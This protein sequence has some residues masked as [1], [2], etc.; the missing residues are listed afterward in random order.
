M[1]R[2]VLAANE[3]ALGPDDG[4]TLFVMFNLAKVRRSQAAAGD[5]AGP[6]A[7]GAAV[8]AEAL[9]RR[10][11]AGN[12]AAG[13]AATDVRILNVVHSLGDLL[14]TRAEETALEAGEVRPSS[15]ARG[16]KKKKKKE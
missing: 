12:E 16:G 10:T 11:L 7:A 1:L 5:S 6:G 14:A 3:T 13:Y 4:R 8:E 9:M 15:A 2:R